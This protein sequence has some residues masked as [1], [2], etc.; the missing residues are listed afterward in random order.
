MRLSS[1]IH[2]D[3]VQSYRHGPQEEA[4]SDAKR[5]R[6]STSSLPLLVR[7]L[8]HNPTALEPKSNNWLVLLLALLMSCQ[9]TFIHSFISQAYIDEGANPTEYSLLFEAVVQK[10][11]N[12]LLSFLSLPTFHQA[13]A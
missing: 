7:G 2:V 9:P 11:L 12:F 5:S 4:Q 6:V 1:C 10:F 3:R 13:L 8:T